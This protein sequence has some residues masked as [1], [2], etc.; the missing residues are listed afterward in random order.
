[1]DRQEAHKI[2]ANKARYTH[3]PWIAY[4]GRDGSAQAEMETADSVK[5]AM[6]ACGT[7]GYW[8]AYSGTRGHIQRWPL[9][10][11]RLRNFRA[12]F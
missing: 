4:V 5:R 8:T 11:L 12:R 7:K 3:K 10:V 6:L 2:A 9:G 1:M